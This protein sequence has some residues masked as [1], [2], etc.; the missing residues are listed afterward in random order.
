MANSYVR[1]GRGT[2]KKKMLQT[3]ST[4]LRAVR[5]RSNVVFSIQF[6]IFGDAPISHYDIYIFLII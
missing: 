2:L 4:L 1:K 3:S 6:N 5:A